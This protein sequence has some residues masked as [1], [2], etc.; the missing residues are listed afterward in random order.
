M[1]HQDSTTKERF[2]SV[3]KMPALYSSL[4]WEIG[5]YRW[6]IFN[7]E[8]N[9]FKSCLLKVQSRWV[10]DLE[11]FEAWLTSN[12]APSTPKRNWNRV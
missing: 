3:A 1:N 5:T 12:E 2:A 11:K 10:I 9:G 4:D 8:T 7:R 6:L